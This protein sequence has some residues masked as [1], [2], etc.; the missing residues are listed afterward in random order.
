MKTI[1][2]KIILS[3]KAIF[4]NG[5]NNVDVMVDSVN[6]GVYKGHPR[7]KFDGFDES[8]FYL[9]NLIVYYKSGM[10]VNGLLVSGN[11]VCTNIIDILKELK[12]KLNFAP[13]IR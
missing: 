2:K 12:E 10:L 5:L 7:I 6:D 9:G 13:N 4:N 1:N 3:T 11:L 8:A